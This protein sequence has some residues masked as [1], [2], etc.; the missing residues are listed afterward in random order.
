MAVVDTLFKP[1]VFSK[2]LLRTLAYIFDIPGI[3]FILVNK[4]KQ[5]VHDIL[6][7]TY[8]IKAKAPHK[9]EKLFIFGLFALFVGELL[10]GS[11]YVKNHYVRNYVQTF[12]IPTGS[13]K[14]SILVGDFILVDKYW[15]RNNLTKQGDIIVFKKD[16]KYPLAL[17]YINRCIAVGGQTVEIKNGNVYIDGDP[18]GE[19]VQLGREYEEY[20][21]GGGSPISLPQ[22]SGELPTADHRAENKQKKERLVEK[23]KVATPGRKS[24]V[25]QHYAD[26][27]VRNDS[28]GPVTVPEGRYF[29]MGDNRD[30][31]SDSRVWGFLPQK[32][33][34]G[35]AGIIYWSWDGLNK[36]VRWSRIGKA[37]Q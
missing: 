36:K 34:M 21:L 8:V 30:N 19:K 10:Y 28:F 31:S 24:Y 17:D 20:D 3:W 2:S 27:Y 12:R 13:M 23:I 5:T 14:P 18:E 37:L 32:D 22:L 15:P 25:I 16:L 35:K 9:L 4:K 26:S 7:K 6:A 1:I 11:D 33:V 29:M